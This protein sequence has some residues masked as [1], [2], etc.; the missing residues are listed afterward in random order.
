MMEKYALSDEEFT[1]CVAM[2][3]RGPITSKELCDAL[4]ISK[5]RARYCLAVCGLPPELLHGPCGRP[6][7]RYR[8]H[9]DHAERIAAR[10]DLQA[11]RRRMMGGGRL[12]G[13]DNPRVVDAPTWP[14]GDPTHFDMDWLGRP[15]YRGPVKAGDAKWDV[16]GEEDCT[17][18]A[19]SVVSS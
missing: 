14:T 3:Q 18:P 17:T 7:H 9:P 10:K 2:M 8:L 6:Q 1:V 13:E 19:G 12:N 5:D 11:F 16:W 15:V 4:D